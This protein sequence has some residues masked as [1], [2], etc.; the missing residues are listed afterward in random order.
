MPHSE[1]IRFSVPFDLLFLVIAFNWRLPFS[2]EFVS[3]DHP[4]M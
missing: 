4:D 1:E 3:F 2:G